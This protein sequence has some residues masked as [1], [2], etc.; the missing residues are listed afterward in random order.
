MENHEWNIRVSSHRNGNI[1]SQ[2]QSGVDKHLEKAVPLTEEWISEYE[3]KRANRTIVFT[4][5]Q[6]M[7]V[8]PEGEKILPNLMQ[9][10]ALEQLQSVV[11]SGEKRALIISATGTGKTIL[12]ALATRQM[13][14]SKTLFIVH[15]E[16]I[17]KKAAQEFAKV[18]EVDD[19]QIGFFVGA[20]RELDKDLVFATVQSLSRKENL[21][22]ISPLQFD[23]VIID[24]VHRSGA[25]SYQSIL[26]HFRPNFTLCLLYTSDAADE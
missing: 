3:Q 11:D 23:L 12:A 1:A 18:L 4:E 5:T 25:E 19:S 2:L 10:E 16:Q 22:S 24:E 15:R 8:S 14:P 26:N 7:E 6:P 13:K 21:A 20:R 17:L 9:V